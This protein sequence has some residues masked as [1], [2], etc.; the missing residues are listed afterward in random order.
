MS[1]PAAVLGDLRGESE[2]PGRSAGPLP[3]AHRA[4]A[5]PAP[6][7]SIAHRIARRVRSDAAAL[8]AVRAEGADADHWLDI[9]QALAGP[10][11]ADRPAGSA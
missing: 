8:L 5:T 11:G 3:A 6:G 2:E 10:A 9:A 1:D 4:R 7:W